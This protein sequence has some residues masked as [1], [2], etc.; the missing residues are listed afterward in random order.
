MQM[1]VIIC[2]HNPR[3]DYLHRTLNGLKAQTLPTGLWELLVV[4]N[5]S[6]PP[7]A[8]DCDLSWHP[9]SRVVIESDLGILPARVRG[10]REARTE[11]ILF[12]DDDNVLAPDYLAQAVAIAHSHPFLGCWGGNIAPEFER[13]PPRWIGRYLPILACSGIE[14]DRW[15][16]SHFTIPPTAGMALRRQVAEAFIRLVEN[17]S[18]R[19]LIGRRGKSGLMNGEDTDLAL[20]ACD[21][22]LGMGQFKNLHLTHLVPEEKLSEEYLLRLTEGSYYCGYLLDAFRG[23]KVGRATA[24]G[25]R[26]FLGKIKRLVFWPAHERRFFEAKMRA[27]LRAVKTLAGLEQESTR[28]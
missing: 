22:G 4:D 8:N 16:N 11:L 2:T 25:V 10:L 14:E 20:T 21:L 24:G 18:R 5:A 17:D 12:V 7:V 6:N 3:K 27:R 13:K 15:S 9:S 28:N 19:Q 1:S 26:S 23:R